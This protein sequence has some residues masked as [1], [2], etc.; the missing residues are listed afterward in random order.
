M[1][2]QT[3]RSLYC[4]ARKRFARYERE[5]T[6]IGD[7]PT[8]QAAGPPRH[9]G[10]LLDLEGLSGDGARDRRRYAHGGLQLAHGSHPCLDAADRGRF[11]VRISAQGP[12]GPLGVA[13]RK[14][15]VVLPKPKPK[16]PRSRG[17]KR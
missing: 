8:A 3:K 6:R 12:S 15:H 13:T 2:T 1:C 10:P 9:D 4:S 5:P 11:R 17:T 14:V 16:K 7:R